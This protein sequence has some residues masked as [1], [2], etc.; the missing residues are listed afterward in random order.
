MNYEQWYSRTHEAAAWHESGDLARAE[1]GWRRLVGDPDV[2]DL[3]RASILQNLALT[4][5]KGERRDEAL[6]IYDI[7]IGLEGVW[8]RGTARAVK[9]NAL[10][11][12]GRVEEAAT[13]LEELAA[14]PWTTWSER[15]GQLAKAQQW[16][17]S[18][19]GSG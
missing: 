5:W 8:H 2:P 9:A 11:L 1:T 14:E 13:M 17:R 3:D 15:H 7:A 6:E 10:A 4:L 18:G 16:R 12:Q 19:S